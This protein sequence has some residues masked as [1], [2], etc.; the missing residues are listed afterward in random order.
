MITTIKW[1]N[2]F[3][4]QCL[5]VYTHRI[6]TALSLISF[7][8]WYSSFENAYGYYAIYM[9]KLN[10]IMHKETEICAVFKMK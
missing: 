8:F 4:L 10:R 9:D 7:L 5:R 3:E 6:K 2:K 1:K